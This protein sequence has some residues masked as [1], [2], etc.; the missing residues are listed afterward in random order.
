MTRAAV[1]A[2][3]VLLVACGTDAIEVDGDGYTS[4]M[5]ALCGGPKAPP[6]VTSGFV[7]LRTGVTMHYV[8]QGP[9]HGPTV[10]F[11][12][13]FTDSHHSFDLNL[14]YLPANRR[15]IAID[16][17]GH[18]LSSAA[19]SYTI[20]D[21]V[22]DVVAFMDAKGIKHASLVGHSMGSFIAHGVAAR[23]PHRIKRLV[24]IGSA[25]TCAGNEIVAGLAEWVD[26][27]TDPI[28]P[29]DV[30][31]FQSSTFYQPVPASYLDTMVE[32]SLRLP[33]ARWQAVLHGLASD[34]HTSELANIKAKTLVLW[35]DQD[36]LFTLEEE[37]ALVAAIPKAK[38]VVFEQ[39][40]HG[41][42]AEQPARFHAEL[43]RFLP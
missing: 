24:L 29:A 23:H 11:L 41:L 19:S 20:P 28:D 8:E 38:L 40:G 39:T 35:G 22:E 42:H 12:H 37:Q 5:S 43:E 2:L 4:Q 17:R 9:K 10:I 7:E 3:A 31:D 30:R 18:G 6:E 25:P 27:F 13:G 16:M 15:A 26:T 33:A 21:F 34:D 14:R 36:G 1:V 32:Q